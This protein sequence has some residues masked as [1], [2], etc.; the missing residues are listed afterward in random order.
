MDGKVVVRCRFALLFVTFF[1][2]AIHHLENEM[3]SQTDCEASHLIVSC[4]KEKLGF[5]K[6]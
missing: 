2:V 1:L 3:S 5:N 4:V 6:T